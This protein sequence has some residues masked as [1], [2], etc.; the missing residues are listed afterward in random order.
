SGFRGPRLPDR[1]SPLIPALSSSER[2]MLLMRLGR[3]LFPYLVG[4]AACVAILIGVM[5]L[6]RADLRAPFRNDG[7]A[8]YSQL[9]VKNVF[10]TGSYTRNRRGA[11]PYGLQLYDFPVAEELHFLLFRG[12]GLFTDNVY[13]AIN[14]FFLLTFVLSTWAAQ[15]TCRRLGL[16]P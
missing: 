6:W 2:G 8:I 12:I 13:K 4:A 5:K 10:E 1:R 3:S 14:V 7:D 9:F 16:G 15:F 11:T